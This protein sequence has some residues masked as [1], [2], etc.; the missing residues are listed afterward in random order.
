[1]PIQRELMDQNNEYEIYRVDITNNPGS[2]GIKSVQFFEWDA[3]I[4]I[5]SNCVKVINL[6][7]LLKTL[8]AVLSIINLHCY[9]W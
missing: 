9:T 3:F 6:V 7:A 4:F 2:T 5:N 8:K 1:M